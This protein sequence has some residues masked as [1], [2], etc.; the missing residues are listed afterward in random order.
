MDQSQH[1]DLIEAPVAAKTAPAVASSPKRHPSAAFIPRS[2][3]EVEWI[4]RAA[5]T[6]EGT[7]WTDDIPGFAEKTMC[8]LKGMELGLGP[9]ESMTSIYVMQFKNKEGGTSMKFGIAAWAQ[10]AMLFRSGLCEQWEMRSG[11]Q[12][13]ELTVKRRGMAQ[14]LFRH[15]LKDYAHRQRQVLEKWQQKGRTGQPDHPWFTHPIKMLEARI[16]TTAI[17]A[18]F[19]D[20]LH[21]MPGFD[22]AVES[23]PGHDEFEAMSAFQEGVQESVD[24]STAEY[25]V[26]ADV[27]EDAAPAADQGSPVVAAAQALVDNA[28]PSVAHVEAPAA[29]NVENGAA[30]QQETLLPPPPPQATASGSVQVPPS[31]PLPQSAAP[32]A[33]PPAFAAALK[34]KQESG[35]AQTG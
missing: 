2:T 1:P 5:M 9:V 20:L 22:E 29:P 19:P 18:L 30:R 26:S 25:Q 27:A 14:R 35:A 12:S 33:L 13:V 17:R 28:Q 3:A 31:A 6:A 16:S 15:H 11:E 32:T 4:V 34:R 24:H 21:G 7:V 10:R 23:S 8:V